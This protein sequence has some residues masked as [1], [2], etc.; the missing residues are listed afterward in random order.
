MGLEDL[1]ELHELHMWGMGRQTVLT[2]HPVAAPGVPASTLLR[3][4][5]GLLQGTYG[6]LHTT[7]QIDDLAASPCAQVRCPLFREGLADATLHAHGH[8]G[9]HGHAH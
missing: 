2:P 8:H 1:A 7:L 5:E 3:R 6:I 4:A 9:H